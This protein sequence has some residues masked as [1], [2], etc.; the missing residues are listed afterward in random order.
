MSAVQPRFVSS[1]NIYPCRFV[2]ISGDNTVAQA[3]AGEYTAGISQEGT[4]KPPLPGETNTYAAEANDL[5]EVFGPG[6]ETQLELGGTVTAGDM[7]KPDADG[8]GVA[9]ATTNYYGAIAKTGGA[10]GE[11]IIVIVER[12]YKA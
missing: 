7:L 4:K 11:K 1:G 5:L 3:G 9:A 12:G 6:Q 8:K 10:S 2:K